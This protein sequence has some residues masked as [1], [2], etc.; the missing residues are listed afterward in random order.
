MQKVLYGFISSSNRILIASK[1]R[2]VYFNA[3]WF[4]ARLIG[5]KN[6]NNVCRPIK[7]VGLVK[8]IFNSDFSLSFNIQMR[9]T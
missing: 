4:Q 6:N 2:A 5:N 7:I 9:Y 3:T 1:Y 8:C